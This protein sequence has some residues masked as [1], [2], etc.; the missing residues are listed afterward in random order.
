[1]TTAFDHI[2][3]GGKPA[4]PHRHAALLTQRIFHRFADAAR[5]C[6]CGSPVVAG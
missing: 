5:D 2:D 4:Q 3:L 1:M 6:H